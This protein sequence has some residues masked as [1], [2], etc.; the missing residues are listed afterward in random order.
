MCQ[1][2]GKEIELLY[3]WKGIKYKI[4]CIYDKV[5]INNEILYNINR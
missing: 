4:I 1:L 3:N 5:I 2:E